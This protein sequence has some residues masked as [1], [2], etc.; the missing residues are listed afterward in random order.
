MNGGAKFLHADF[1]SNPA[2]GIPYITVPGSQPKVPMKFTYA[3]ESDPGPYPYPADAPVEG[4]PN[5]TGDRHVIVVDTGTCTLYETF[6][7]YYV[8]PGWD[9]GSG[10][11][12]NLNSNVLRPDYWTSAD[13]AGLPI[14]AGLTRYYEVQAGAINHALRFTVARTQRAFVHP[15]THFASTSTDVND[16]PMGLRVRLKSGYDVSHF[17]GE[18]RVVL[19]ALK[20]YGMYVADNG[21]DWFVSGETNPNWND[22]DLN[23]LKTVPASAFEVVKLGHIIR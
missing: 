15:A 6:G 9:A 11:K 3:S 18:S 21:S 19:T 22:D 16:P 8:N 7:S 5:S 17:T 13:A 23:Q 12:F 20:R 1:G 14:F 2:Y 4:G 10:A